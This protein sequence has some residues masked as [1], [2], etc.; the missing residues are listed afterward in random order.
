MTRI[1]S[2]RE[3][4][5]LAYQS[6]GSRPDGSLAYKA[7]S[8]YSTLRFANS[9][10]ISTYELFGQ[11]INQA[12]GLQW[13]NM[14]NPG[15][16]PG[17]QSMSVYGISFDLDL[18]DASDANIPVILNDFSTWMRRSVLTFGRTNSDWDAQFPLA[19]LLPPIFNATAAAGNRFGDFARVAGTYQFVA[20]V[21]LGQNESFSFRIDTALPLGAADPIVAN[22]V[23]MR[24]YLDGALTKKVAAN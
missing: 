12:G 6:Q 16:V 2:T 9:A 7:Y 1:V 19:K 5:G 14:T 24:F 18:G 15:T 22:S 11:S 3:R 23:N 8:L 4:R 20:P 13:T 21:I 10:L 17:G